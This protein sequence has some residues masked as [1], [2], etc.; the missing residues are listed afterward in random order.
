MNKRIILSAIFLLLAAVLVAC[1]L[2]EAD[3]HTPLVAAQNSGGKE[4]NIYYRG[5]RN[6]QDDITFEALIA[7]MEAKDGDKLKQL[8]APKVVGPDLPEQVDML[9]DYFDGTKVSSENPASN[10]SMEIEDGQTVQYIMSTYELST[11]TADYRIAI[12]LCTDDTEN[13][14]NVG[15]HSLYI[16]KAVNGNKGMAYWGNHEWLPGIVIQDSTV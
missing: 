9:L 5:E 15:L 1:T 10:S 16:T 14:G 11:T 2:P 4:D 13:P 6:Q 3:T 12:K 8:F 7:A